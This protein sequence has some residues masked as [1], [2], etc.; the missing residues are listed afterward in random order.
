MEWDNFAAIFLASYDD[1][2]KGLSQ[3]SRRN[4]RAAEK[5]GVIV[6]I[7]PLDNELVRGIKEVYDEV[8][9]RQGVRNSHYREDLQ[10][11]RRKNSAFLGRD[12]FLAAEAG[13][14]LIGF[15]QMIYADKTARIMQILPKK[16]HL[17]KRPSSA[18]IAKAVR[19]CL[20]KRA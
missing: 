8:P 18:L 11:V 12:A 7:A 17:D 16:A 10:T 20:L 6:R 15:I 9:V 5:K 19:D 3:D 13:G 2:W 14:E 4:I 1:W